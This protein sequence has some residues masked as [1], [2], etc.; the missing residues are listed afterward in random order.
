MLHS[1]LRAHLAGLKMLD[2]KGED[3]LQLHARYLQLEELILHL[4]GDSV[5]VLANA[6]AA[7]FN[8]HTWSSSL[9][10]LS[11]W[12]FDKD[13]IVLQPLLNALPCAAIRLESL[14]IMAWGGASLLDWSPLLQLSQLASLRVN[15]TPS[16]PQLA[17]VKQLYGLTELDVMDGHWTR[18]DLRSLLSDSDGPHQLQ[19][20]QKISMQECTLD[21]ESMQILLT[22]PA[23]TELQ[24]YQLDPRCF[25]LLHS[26]SKL[27]RLRVAPQF[28]F[29]P[30]ADA[31]ELLS[32]LRAL[33]NLLSLEIIGRL[34]SAS[35][36]GTMI[37]GLAAAVPQLRELRLRWFSPLPSLSRLAACTQLRSLHLTDCG[38]KD[39]ESNA[40]LLQLLSSLRHLERCFVI[41]CGLRLSD[42]Q[43]A[44]LTPPSVLIPSLQ[45]FEWSE[46]FD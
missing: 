32:S 3:L 35:I 38:R 43:R 37:D 25:P 34:L 15:H 30:A 4:D 41:N 45:H 14:G 21:V 5:E 42:E 17:V 28:G 1:P 23:L 27:R 22:L 16:P 2:A 9:R 7:A 19:R 13:A 36:K 8:A 46:P 11:R 18:E 10:S 6:N 26:F 33:S 12:E 44:Q 20:L 31:S 29:L 40:D 39:G 24:P